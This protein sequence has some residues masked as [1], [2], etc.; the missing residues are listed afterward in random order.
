MEFGPRHLRLC[1]P[2]TLMTPLKILS[3]LLICSGSNTTTTTTT[4]SLTNS[5]KTQ[6]WH[7][8]NALSWASQNNAYSSILELSADKNERVLYV[9]GPVSENQVLFSLPSQLVI[10]PEVAKRS[11]LIQKYAPL[12][13][14]SHCYKIVE[15]VFLE[16]V[17]PGA[18]ERSE[19]EMYYNLLPGFDFDHNLPIV[20]WAN[21]I[22]NWRTGFD[23]TGPHSPA[24]D[25]LLNP[26]VL[27]MFWHTSMLELQDELSWYFKKEGLFHKLSQDTGLP[28]SDIFPVFLW[29]LKTVW[30]RS[31]PTEKGGCSLIPV[32]DMFNHKS[33][34][35]IAAGTL[36]NGTLIVFST[37]SFA[38]PQRT[39]WP[40]E[41]DYDKEKRKC[42]EDML[43]SFGFLPNDI[44]IC[45]R[46][47]LQ[48]KPFHI[49]MGSEYKAMQASMLF[50]ILPD[51]YK[52]ISEGDHQHNSHH[53][54]ITLVL[55]ESFPLRIMAALR[56]LAANELILKAAPNG[57]TLEYFSKFISFVHEI[58][59]LHR[60]FRILTAVLNQIE[61][62][63]ETDREMLAYWQQVDRE[64]GTSQDS[65]LKDNTQQ[66]NNSTD[67][68]FSNTK[69]ASRMV[70]ALQ[71]RIHRRRILQGAI[72]EI[73]A[74]WMKL[75]E[76]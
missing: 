50:D 47:S 43:W 32:I 17:L 46:F 64:L 31:F 35:I 29:A 66:C 58:R 19:F 55:G 24:L 15:F 61:N 20:D 3:F 12:L 67:C 9:N 7:L 37:K 73:Q 42:S 75:L 76:N 2:M 18:R 69:E 6:S 40:V 44:K 38:V 33:D 48:V 54:E 59:T 10:N 4:A 45:A 21:F 34:S 68:R 25:I 22:G 14:K 26:P 28:L 39:A 51:V 65:A 71:V 62:S 30:T 41:L 53:L 27:G 1:A 52:P 49:N 74:K 36:E 8:Q 23:S 11:S 63:E 57:R 13:Q 60:A 5:S 16:N 56:I 72:E 70:I